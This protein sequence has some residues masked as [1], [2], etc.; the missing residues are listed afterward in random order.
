MAWAR[1]FYKNSAG[2]DAK[3]LLVTEHASLVKR[4]ALHIKARLP[5][6]VQLDDLMQSGMVG[7][8]EAANSFDASKGASFETYAGIRIR[9]SMIDEIRRGDWTPRSVH[10]NARLISETMLK[11]A[12][13]LGRDATD[14]EMAA[15]L[16]VPVSEYHTMVFEASTS[17]V[18]GIDDLGVTE[19]VILFDG[20]DTTENAPFNGVVH[21]RYQ[22]ALASAIE[23][24]PQREAM[25]LSMYYV[26]EL[27]LKEIGLVLD[28]SE[29]RISQILS[30]AIVRLRTKLRDWL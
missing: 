1:N 28:V 20:Q 3:T 4:I 8:L 7:L 19:D 6:S 5:E 26:D 11:L 29:S 13:K 18:I 2:E 30:Q 9:G 12:H 10:K 14:T 22:V 24:L 21:D 17:S 16:G 23:K 15:E 25:V 27:N